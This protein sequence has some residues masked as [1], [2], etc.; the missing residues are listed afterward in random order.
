M[1]RAPRSSVVPI[2]YTRTTHS[3]PA[4]T[5]PVPPPVSTPLVQQTSTE[6]FADALISTPSTHTGATNQKIP[7]GAPEDRA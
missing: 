3:A 4:A 7:S 1:P 2:A 5:T 6:A